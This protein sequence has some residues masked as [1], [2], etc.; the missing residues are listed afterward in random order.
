[1]EERKCTCPLPWVMKRYNV[2]LGKSETIRMCCLAKS[3]GF[4]EVEDIEKETLPTDPKKLAAI[5][6]FIQKEAKS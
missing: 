3:L 6:K 4:L 2:F 1:M 5:P